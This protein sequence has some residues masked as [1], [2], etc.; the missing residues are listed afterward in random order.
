[1][2]HRMGGWMFKVHEAWLSAA[3]P[4]LQQPRPL[5]SIPYLPAHQ[6]P[7]QPARTFKP[8]KRCQSQNTSSVSVPFCARSDAH[9]SQP[10]ARPRKCCFTVDRAPAFA[11]CLPSALPASQPRTLSHG[12]PHRRCQSH[13]P[14]PRASTPRSTPDQQGLSSS[15]FSSQLCSRQC[16]RCRCRCCSSSSNNNNN[17]ALAVF[18]P[19]LLLLLQECLPQA[20]FCLALAPRPVDPLVPRIIPG[21]L[22]SEETE[23]T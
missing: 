8:D 14:R 18:P 7:S 3:R 22:W 4:T 11:P 9:C 1:M 6:R 19:V 2:R 17:K 21:R 20:L 10:D 12:H 15:E 13:V 23:E 16:C 5:S